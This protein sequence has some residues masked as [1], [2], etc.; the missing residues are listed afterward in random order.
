MINFENILIAAIF[1]LF[2]IIWVIAAKRENGTFSKQETG[3]LLLGNL[4]LYMGLIKGE[5]IMFSIAI[6]S[7]LAS[8]GL[9]LFKK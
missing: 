6:G 4:S 5:E 1:V 8:I 9:T 7:F 3:Q 2:N